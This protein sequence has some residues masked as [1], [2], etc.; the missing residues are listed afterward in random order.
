VGV[1]FE[2]L[3]PLEA[4]VVATVP[5]EDTTPGV[6]LLSGR[7][8]LTWSPLWTCDC[9]PAWKDPRLAALQGLLD[10]ETH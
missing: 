4:G 7:V 8:M 3:E 5:T 10:R 6:V 9:K 1:L 2:S